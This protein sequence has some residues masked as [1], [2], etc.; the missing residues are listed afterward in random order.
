MIGYLDKQLAFFEDLSTA[1]SSLKTFLVYYSRGA[2][3]YYK[4]LFTQ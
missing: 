2:L 1:Y 4:L 3:L